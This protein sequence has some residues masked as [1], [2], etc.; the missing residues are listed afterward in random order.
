MRHVMP[1]HDFDHPGK[2]TYP[3]TCTNSGSQTPSGGFTSA[4]H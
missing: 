3:L 4:F 1:D 2:K